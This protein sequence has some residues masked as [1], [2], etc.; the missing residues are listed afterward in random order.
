[1]GPRVMGEKRARLLTGNHLTRR[2][3]TGMAI[4]ARTSET[5]SMPTC[6]SLPCVSTFA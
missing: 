2:D 5:G 3:T 4:S 1:M 6:S